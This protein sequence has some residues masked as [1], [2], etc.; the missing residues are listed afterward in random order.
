[1]NLYVSLKNVIKLF[2]KIISLK[3]FAVENI[4]GNTIVI[5]KQVLIRI[6]NGMTMKHIK[7][8]Q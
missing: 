2:I 6:K 7:H 3:S 4:N 5:K 1:M 8:L